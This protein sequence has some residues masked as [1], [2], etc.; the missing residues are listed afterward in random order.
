MILK[1]YRYRLYPNNEQRTMLHK[2][3][4]CSRFVY[5]WALETKIKRYE[6]DQTSLSC[7]ELM[8]EMKRTIKQEKE[9]L[10]EVNSQSLQMSIR[11]LDNAF[12]KFFR[13]KTGFP[14]F[15][16]KSNRQSFQCPQ[17]VSIDFD[18]QMIS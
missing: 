1:A 8:N 17:S 3:F 15:K 2:H 7:F 12:T 16:K 14:K 5:N 10:K 13:D 9:W 11:N 4:G 6:K 18:S